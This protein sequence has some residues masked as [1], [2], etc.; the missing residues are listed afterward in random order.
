MKMAEYEA[1]TA[2]SRVPPTVVGLDMKHVTCPPD[3]DAFRAASRNS[4]F[5]E[6]DVLDAQTAPGGRTDWLIIYGPKS[7]LGRLA[8][9]RGE[10]VQELPRVDNIEIMETN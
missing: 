8:S 4:L 7:T 1:M 5:V 6:F 2:S 3:P 9:S 10:T